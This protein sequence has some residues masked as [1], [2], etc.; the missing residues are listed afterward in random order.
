MFIM[1]TAGGTGSGSLAGAAAAGDGCSASVI[2]RASPQVVEGFFIAVDVGGLFLQPGGELVDL[3]LVLGGLCVGFSLLVATNTLFP[4]YDGL[5]QLLDL[6]DPSALHL[7]GGLL[8]LVA[9]RTDGSLVGL[10]ERLDL[11]LLLFQR[12]H[13]AV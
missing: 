12:V 3:R 8:V 6:V 4:L 13:V 11:S 5:R 7:G 9:K 10:L 1:P 2:L